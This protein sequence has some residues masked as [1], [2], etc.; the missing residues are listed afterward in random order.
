VSYPLEQVY[1]EVAFI[2]YYLHWRP[3]TLLGMPH[4]ER[5]KWCEEVSKINTKLNDDRG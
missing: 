3:D 2:G 4:R 5:R 1:E